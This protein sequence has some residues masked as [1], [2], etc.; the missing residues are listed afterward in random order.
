[1]KQLK[2]P[3]HLG[4]KQILKRRVII[5]SVT[6]AILA[7][8]GSSYALINSGST[9]ATETPVIQQQ[10]ND[11]EQRISTVEGQVDKTK[12]DI[13]DNKQ[14]TDTNT[15][16]IIN[17]TTRIV[18]V[19]GKQDTQTEQVK[20]LQVQV[21]QPEPVKSAVA[22]VVV[23]PVDPMTVTKH[24]YTFSDREITGAKYSSKLCVWQTVGGE[25]WWYLSSYENI[26]D[27]VCEYSDQKILTPSAT[28]NLTNRAM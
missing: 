3:K 11:H 14:Q 7:V 17:N 13:A 25:T 26:R 19:Q 16:A 22:P 2:S 18:T 4:I 20:S 6:L 15:A 27:D 8:T 5:S 24:T 12:K 1:M 10:V 28:R 23:K 9:Q 21:S